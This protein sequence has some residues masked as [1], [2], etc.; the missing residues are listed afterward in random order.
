M[1]DKLLNFGA[2]L[3][4]ISPSLAIFGKASGKQE[5]VVV[6]ADWVNFVGATLEAVDISTYHDTVDN[7]DYVFSVAVDDFDE[8]CE[9][10][11]LVKA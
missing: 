9:L 11:G 8:V 5:I 2:G 4:W 10:L 1:I 7:D 6:P 3:D